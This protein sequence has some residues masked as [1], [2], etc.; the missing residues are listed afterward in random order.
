VEALATLLWAAAIT[1][2]GQFVISA[3]TIG[4]VGP[5]AQATIHKSKEADRGVHSLP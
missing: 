2:G 1:A 5:Q 3:E 4:A